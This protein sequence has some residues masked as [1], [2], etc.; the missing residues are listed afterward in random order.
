MKALY[1]LIAG[2]M[3]EMIALRQGDVHAG[4]ARG[5]SVV[6]SI[7]AGH[8]YQAECWEQGDLVNKHR[9]WVKLRLDDGSEG[10]ITSGYLRKNKKITKLLKH[11]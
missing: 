2:V 10:Y 5:E 9:H 11:C 3:G 8:R 7:T 6:S 1:F 4:P